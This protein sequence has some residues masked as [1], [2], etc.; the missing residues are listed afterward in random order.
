MKVS[1][2]M[3]GAKELPVFPFLEALVPIVSMVKVLNSFIFT[4][5]F[6]N[7]IKSF[8]PVPIVLL[9]I[10]YFSYL[11]YNTIFLNVGYKKLLS[12]IC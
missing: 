12:G 3:K 10:V 8:R 4:Q 7:K 1:P 6:L 5:D 9:L 11:N 2:E